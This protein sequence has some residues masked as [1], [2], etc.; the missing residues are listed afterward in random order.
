MLKLKAELKREKT[1]KRHLTPVSTSA[2]LKRGKKVKK[3]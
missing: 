2:D 1:Q 3:K